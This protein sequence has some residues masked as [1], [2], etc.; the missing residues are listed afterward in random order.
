VPPRR[1][2]LGCQYSSFLLTS[3]QISEVEV[4]NQVALEALL[5]NPEARQGLIPASA[6]AVEALSRRL[7]A[8]EDDIIPR[9][10]R[11][12]QSAG[13][14]A[15]PL[16]L[17]KPTRRASSTS[18]RASPPLDAETEEAVLTLE[19]MALGKVG[20]PRGCEPARAH[21]HG[22]TDTP[23]QTG[24]S[25]FAR[26]MARCRVPIACSPPCRGARPTR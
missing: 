14:A 5:A 23:V 1:A 10:R 22:P 3:V 9:L 20:L 24:S 11:L 21:W 18:S 26:I 17:P 19:D 25:A 15:P 6:S 8:L 4:S 12:E 2:G 7:A 13:I 16:P